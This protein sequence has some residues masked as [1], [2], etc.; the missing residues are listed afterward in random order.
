MRKIS[1]GLL[2]AVMFLQTAYASTTYSD[3]TFI[4]PRDQVSNL[5]M[6]FTTWH[7]RL[8]KKSDGK[9]N[10]S[11]QA[12]L[13]YQES[14]NK[15]DMGNYFG[16][17][18][19]INDTSK[20]K[21]ITNTLG[22]SDVGHY[23]DAGRTVLK[24]SY[25]FIHNYQ[26]ANSY[27]THGYDPVTYTDENTASGNIAFR[28]YQSI[29]GLRLDYN[30]DLDRLC[31][32]LFFRVTAPVVYVRNSMN[33]NVVAPVLKQGLP[34]GNGTTTS[35]TGPQKDML[36]YLSG[37][38]RNTDDENKQE[39][40]EYAK[41]TGGSH[42]SS[43]VADLDLVLGY[44]F[45]HDKYIR[46]AIDIDV[47]V[48]TG[49]RVKGEYLFEPVHGN[50]HHWGIGCGLDMGLTFFKHE[51]KSIEFLLVGNYKYL[52]EATEKR[53]LDYIRVNDER[54]NA[55]Y[56][57]LGGQANV[58]GVFPLANVLTQDL[59][60][61]PGSQID[62]IAQ[63]AFNWGKFT[64]DVGYNIFAKQTEHL[65]LKNPWSDHTYAQADWEYNS[66]YHEVAGDTLNL[67]KTIDY[68][69]DHRYAY[70]YAG[71]PDETPAAINSDH[72]DMDKAKGPSQTTHKVYA[73]LGYEFAKQRF[74]VMLGLGGSYE[75]AHRNSALGGYAVWAK[76][77]L[78]W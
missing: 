31:D 13:F 29:Y 69:G 23:G 67:F 25:D 58:A 45:A 2:M 9:Y 62:A 66:N 68:T 8:H 40:L 56:Y 32:G 76:G 39:P 28:P 53:T 30:Q 55:G 63:L 72:L 57:N 51:N 17:N 33:F 59:R 52:F 12:V 18:R 44:K 4:M 38:I 71:A 20:A 54:V 26:G 41:I 73:G 16:F 6:Q 11:V 35:L 78:S 5:P 48:P 65:S 10:G 43:G 50:G 61:T 24:Y 64:F 37:N 21:D 36:D 49:K 77:A 15:G 19:N 7:N 60:I 70:A 47:L 14:E 42:S 34:V 22:I 75:H 74:P 46:A 27:G 3:K 1:L